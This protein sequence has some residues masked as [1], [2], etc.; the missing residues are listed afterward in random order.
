MAKLCTL[1]HQPA[2]SGSPEN[3][4]EVKFLALVRDINDLVRVIEPLS[5]AD[6]RKVCGRIERGAVG[7]EDDAGRDILGIALL[8]YIDNE[9]AV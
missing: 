6:R 3:L 8:S 4:L 5:L 1:R 9:S 2:L 7:L